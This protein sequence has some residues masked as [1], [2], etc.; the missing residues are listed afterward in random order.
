MAAAEVE[1]GREFVEQQQETHA[2]EKAHGGRH[3]GPRAAPVLHLD[4][5]NQQRPDGGGYHHAGGEAQQRLLQARGHGVLHQKDKG[6][7]EHG[8]QQG[9]EES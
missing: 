2:E 9:D 6:G 5:G 1:V 3:D 4:G 8:A 7:A